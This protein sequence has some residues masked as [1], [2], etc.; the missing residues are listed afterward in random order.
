MMMGVVGCPYLAATYK[1]GLATVEEQLVTYKKNETI[2]KFIGSKITDN[3]KKGLG[4]HVVPPPH[5]LIY[6]GP[7]KL[8]L[9]YS[10]LDEFKEPEFKGYGPRDSKLESNI[11]HDKKSDDSKEYSDD[12]FVKEQVSEDTSSFVESP[13]NVDKETAFSV[14]KK[15]KFFKP[16]NHDKPVRKSV[17]P[18]IAQVNTVREKQL[19]VVKASACWVWR[20]T[21]PKG[22]S[23]V[24]KRHNYIDARGRSKSWILKA[25]DTYLL[26]FKK[27]DGGYVTFGEEHMVEEFMVKG[28]I[29]QGIESTVL[30]ESHHT[31]TNDPSTSQPPTLTPS[32]QTTHDAEEHATMPYDSPLPRVQS[33]GSVEDSLTLNELTVLYTKLSK[34][35]KDLQS[36]L[37]QTK[38]TYG[39][40]YTKLILR[41]KKL[42][43]KV[44]TSQHRRRE[45]VVL[46]DDEEDLEDPSKQ[47]R[48]IVEIDRNPSISLVQDEGTSWIQEDYEIQGRTSADTEILLDQEEPTELVEDLGSGEKGEKEISTVILEVSNAVENLVYIRRSAEKRKDKGKAIMKEDKSGGYKQSHFKRMSYEDIRL[49]FK[50]VWDQIHAFVLMDS[51]IKNEVMKKSGFDLQQ[52]QFANEKRIGAKLDDESAKR[53]KLKDVTEEEATA[54]YEKEKKE[55]RLSLKIIHNDDSEVNYEPLFRKI[56]I[57]SWEYQLLGNM[58]AKDMEVCKLTRADGS[59]SYHGNIQAFLRRLDRQDLNDLYSLVQERFQDHP[60]E[61]HDLLLWGDLRMIFDLDENDEL[62]MNQLD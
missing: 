30:V 18:Y 31:P 49:I 57:V 1:R 54:E 58:K 46:S 6:N 19:N 24:F 26:D 62:W 7:T 39:A 45:R 3:S 44:K 10:G 43:H 21:R 29:D 16:K 50:R 35:V 2:D 15:I 61:G 36:N 11:N 28:Q 34:R 8:D 56:P 48:K 23:L 5:P 9:S 59:S 42:E 53:Q 12:S 33:L 47:G 60:L 51:K 4:Y 41:V 27:F 25:H 32:M 17:R 55:F 22:A 52:K 40:A 14:D 20:P 37:Q 38:L 13:L